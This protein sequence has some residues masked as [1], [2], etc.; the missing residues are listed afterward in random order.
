M[1]FCRQMRLYNNGSKFIMI[2]E[3]CFSFVC[4]NNHDFTD[5]YTPRTLLVILSDH[6]KPKSANLLVLNT[7]H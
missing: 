1:E 2:D 7:S 6:R 4:L 3:I 5:K